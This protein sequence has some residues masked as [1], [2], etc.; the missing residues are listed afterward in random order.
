[1]LRI[2]TII[3][4]IVWVQ[5][6]LAQF[7]E[8]FSSTGQIA[9]PV[10]SGNTGH[11]IVNAN[12]QLQLN[13]QSAGDSYIYT[14]YRMPKDSVMVDL[15][16]RM[17]FDPSDNNFTKVYLFTDNPVEAQANGYMLRLGENGTNDAIKIVRLVN[18]ASTL[19]ATASLG[20]IA[21]DPAQARLRILIRPDGMW[22]LLT[23]YSGSFLLTTDLEFKENLLPLPDSVYFGIFCRYTSTRLTHFYYDDIAIQ[24]I[25]RDTI[26]PAVVQLEIPDPRRLRLGFSEIPDENSLRNVQHYNVNNG[27]G[28]PSSVVYSPLSPNIAELEFANSI[29]SGINYTL[30]VNGVSDRAG[31]VMNQNIPFSYAVSPTK[32]DIFL[33]EV[34]T[35]PYVGGED[36]IELYNASDKFIQLNGLTVRNDSRNENRRITENYILLPGE[37]VA[38]SDNIDFLKNIYQPPAEA[39]FMRF[40]LPALNVADAYVMLISDTPGGPAV[41]D[42]F[43]YTQKMHYSLIDNTKGVSLEKINITGPSNDRNNWHSAS[44]QFRWATPGYPNSN[45][46]RSSTNEEEKVQLVN[47]SFSPDGDGYED[48]LLIRFLPEKPGYLATVKIYD[49]EGFLV[50]DLVDNFLLGTDNTVKWD[51]VNNEGSLT[52][53]GMYIVQSRLFH[54][55]GQTINSR[56]VAV[57]AVRL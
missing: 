47:K 40:R 6:A 2:V 36:F 16:F 28:R 19:I 51:G 9:P 14:K 50:R 31:N 22:E 3:L 21:R 4:W 52:K 34:L 25:I 39:R 20:A 38:L 32:G 13:A 12:R 46:V 37:Y 57:L 18:G 44:Q 43:A 41:I 5:Q 8:D 30:T 53:T 7:T 11:F 15:Y 55:D 33:T 10:W 1:M 24:N 27:L 48:V 26:P 45:R 42:S 23:D 29:R 35:D 49:A 56:K 17:N 54:P